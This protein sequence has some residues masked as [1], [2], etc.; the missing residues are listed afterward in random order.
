M[1]FTESGQ[2]GTPCSGGGLPRGPK[3]L[4]RRGHR[5]PGSGRTGLPSRNRAIFL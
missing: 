3:P 2:A 4:D 5:F 1:A